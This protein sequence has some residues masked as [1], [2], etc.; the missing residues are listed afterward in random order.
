DY[1]TTFGEKNPNKQ[2]QK[3]QSVVRIQDAE[4]VL[5][6]AYHYFAAM[7]SKLP[8][9]YAVSQT[10]QEIDAHMEQLIPINFVDLT[11]TITPNFSE[12][13]DITDPIIVE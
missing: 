8:Q 10:R 11:P 4:N 3:L 5:R 9:K 7:E 13:P 1:Y 12:K 2:K 6:D